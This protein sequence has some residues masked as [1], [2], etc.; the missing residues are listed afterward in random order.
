MIDLSFPWALLLLPAPL[1]LWWVAPPRREAV[2]AIRVP[3]FDALAQAAN[4][5]PRTGATII[6]RNVLQM[7]VATVVWLC[8]VLALARP[9]WVGDPIE[10]N[11]AARDIMLAVDISGSMD[12]RD[13]V[14]GDGAPLSRLD[15]VKQ[16]LG[17]FIEARKDD[18]VGL[19]IFGSKAYVQVPFTRDLQTAQ[20]LLDRLE[21]GMAGPHTVLGDAI[22]LA[23]KTFEASKV[24]Q[25]FLILL[26][27]GSDTG[28]RMT[29]LNAASVAERNGVEIFTIGVGD[30]DAG[31]EERVD[32]KVLQQVAE[33]SGGRFFSAADTTA[34]STVYKRIEK[35]VPRETKQSTF[36]P[37]R[38]LVHLPAGGAVL[39]VLICYV[40]LLFR[41]GLA[42]KTT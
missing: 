33:K 38:S 28:S 6:R 8:L 17:R 14:S 18:R 13:F 41:T 11:D 25:R 16:V 42:G 23:I 32:F 19:I 15:A 9:E 12:Q 39:L 31:G 22:G 37:R 4:E 1:V 34:L 24:E 20:A 36:R 26:T 5:T 21:V 3:F 2:S 7:L 30:P 40:I 10:S 27:D 29:P 35:L